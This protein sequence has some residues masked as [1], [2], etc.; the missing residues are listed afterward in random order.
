[1]ITNKVKNKK[2]LDE[3][4][5][6]VFKML[7]RNVWNIQW[8]VIFKQQLFNNYI[9]NSFVDSVWSATYLYIYLLSSGIES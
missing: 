9:P 7:N 8:V 4:H 1:M 5:F 3:S 6:F 2:W